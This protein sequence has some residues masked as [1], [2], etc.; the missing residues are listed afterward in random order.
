MRL[1]L[2]GGLS[3]L[4]FDV[5]VESQGMC[6]LGVVVLKMS[7]F[8]W[9]SDFQNLEY[10]GRKKELSGPRPLRGVHVD[11]SKLAI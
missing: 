9:L 11:S 3:V 7:D 2:L 8:P 10:P 6:V 1:D 5:R 4:F